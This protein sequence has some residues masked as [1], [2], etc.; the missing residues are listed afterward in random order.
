MNRLLLFR[1]SSTT[2]YCEAVGKIL[3]ETS[4]A[5]C[6]YARMD[7]IYCRLR[8]ITDHISTAPSGKAIGKLLHETSE[9]CCNYVRI[10]CRLG[11]HGPRRSVDLLTINNPAGTQ[12]PRIDHRGEGGHQHNIVATIACVAAARQPRLA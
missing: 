5:G 9:V 2:P 4:E 1:P 8:A 3:H 11:Y 10:D 6:N 12:R 7:Y